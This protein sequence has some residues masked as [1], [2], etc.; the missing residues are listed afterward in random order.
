MN[1]KA[2]QLP[3]HRE[4]RV[5]SYLSTLEKLIARLS[6]DELLETLKEDSISQGFISIRINEIVESTLLREKEKLIEKLLNENQ[7]LEAKLQ[8]KLSRGKE[9]VMLNSEN[10]RKEGKTHERK[11]SKRRESLNKSKEI[12]ESS[13]SLTL[14]KIKKIK[15]RYKQK[16]L[17]KFEEESSN[18]RTEVEF[19]RSQIDDVRKSTCPIEDYRDLRSNHE[20]T[21]REV[22]SLRAEIQQKVLKIEELRVFRSKYEKSLKEIEKLKGELTFNTEKSN[23]TKLKVST[24]MSFLQ[25]KKAQAENLNKFLKRKLAEILSEVQDLRKA[26][27]LLMNLQR[28]ISKNWSFILSDFHRDLARKLSVHIAGLSKN[29]KSSV[30]LTRENERYLSELQRYRSEKTVLEARSL[31]QKRSLEEKILCLEA[32]IGEKSRTIENLKI[33]HCEEISKLKCDFLKETSQLHNSL[34]SLQ[35]RNETIVMKYDEEMAFF[36]TNY[37]ND[38]KNLKLEYRNRLEGL[39]N[40]TKSSINN[41]CNNSGELEEIQENLKNLLRV[42]EKQQKEK[43]RR[44]SFKEKS[45]ESFTREKN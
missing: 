15:Q 25:K 4:E 27:D 39:L 9:N 32:E 42:A 17:K 45:F 1:L 13:N 34:V 14:E 7:A 11:E 12:S 2:E 10:T 21:L 31:S 18:T 8:D 37:L 19:L 41:H 35:K 16:Y 6:G 5:R 30:L 28:N 23:E 33:T 36:Q 38:L 43:K 40:N 29:S 24:E 44:A 26:K 3:L 20:K 22:D